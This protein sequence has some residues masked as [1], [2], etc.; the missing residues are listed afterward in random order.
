MAF[1]YSKAPKAFL[2]VFRICLQNLYGNVKDL[3]WTKQFSNKLE[4]LHSL[5]SRPAIK[6]H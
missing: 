4:D 2:L 1:F 3:E 5:I 6:Q